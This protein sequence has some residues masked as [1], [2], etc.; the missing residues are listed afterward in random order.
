M[1]DKKYPV[2]ADTAFELLAEIRGVERRMDR[3]VS[4]LERIAPDLHDLRET[5]EGTVIHEI[6]SSLGRMDQRLAVIES[7]V[8]GAESAAHAAAAEAK[9]SRAAHDATGKIPIH[10]PK[11][12]SGQVAKAMRAAAKID[13]RTWLAI[14]V[15]LLAAGVAAGV[16]IAVY[17]LVRAIAQGG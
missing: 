11:E 15:V 13:P 17:Q 5:F 6:R 14:A 4:A 1:S 2:D 9:A 7:N 3:A 10:V 12:D 16:G 8:S